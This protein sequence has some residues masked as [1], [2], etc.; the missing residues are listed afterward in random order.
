[1]DKSNSSAKI[2]VVGAG[3][4]GVRTAQVLAKHTRK[5]PGVEITLIDKNPFHTLMTELHEV[6]GA[7]CEPSSVRIPLET[8]FGGS[9]V[10]V[11]VDRVTSID[12]KTKKVITTTKEMDYDY[13]VLG[14]GAEPEFFGI[15]GVQEFSHTLWS[16]DDAVKIRE[17]IEGLFL[18]ASREADP[19]KR[20][21][22]LTLTVAGAGF[23]GVEMLGE[24]LE[25]R[26]PL[27]REY[28]IDEKEVRI[29][30]VEAMA[31][32]LPI[33]HKD[34]RKP[35]TDFITKS[36]GEILL[37]TAI[38]EV[39]AQ[40]FTTKDGRRVD[41]GILIWTCGVKGCKFAGELNI[42][43]AKDPC[44]N[45]EGVCVEE[46][47]RFNIKKK[48][49]L[50]TNIFLQSADSE[51]VY[52]V[53]DVLW[54]SE[55]GRALPQIVETAI[56]TG[57]TAAKN[58]LRDMENKPKLVHKPEYHGFMVSIGSRY[59]VADL[60]GVRLRGFMAMAM[61]HLINLHYLWEVAGVNSCWHYI[62]H[63]FLNIKDKRDQIHGHA[64]AKI[65]AYWALPLR[66]FT[67]AMWA[68]QG[69]DKVI[70]GWLAPYMGSKTGWMFSKG[71]V[72]AGLPVTP[73]AAGGAAVESA[74]AVAAATE[75][76]YEIIESVSEVIAESAYEGADALAASS[77]EIGEVVEAVQQGVADAVAA[78][79]FK[80][81]NLSKD[82]DIEKFL[83]NPI[84]PKD[85][86]LVQWNQFFMDNVVS[87][88]PFWLLQA[89][90]T[91]GE[92]AIGLALMAGLFTWPAAAASI[93]LCLVFTMS[94]MF[95]WTQLWYLFAALVF[96]GGSG[97]SVGLDNYVLPPLHRWWNGTALARKTKFFLGEPRYRHK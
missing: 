96:M 4:S 21:K 15:K 66:V 17:K 70:K 72:Q 67:G 33:L 16:Y 97:R 85:F 69:F 79:S 1:M 10:Q 95:A 24:L 34:L 13:L 58:I 40:G 6:A 94:G 83:S 2:I 39:D 29:L 22:L 76:G 30:L 84:L 74:D 77:E 64:A 20:K 19:E 37:N 46:D 80:F 56:Q 36:G 63:H 38:S 26:K 88:V 8:I 27:C 73:E 55:K 54:L 91:L 41:N 68:L 90:I 7:R 78:A 43:H 65:P 57:E 31:D 60:M 14:L 82:V 25:W 9:K 5:N 23:T 3:Y 51:K 45:Q 62:S 93:A 49:R 87:Q 50:I 18:Q 52:V 32:I 42:S 44:E 47:L 61:K 48:S 35:A 89:G 28:G 81:T 12:F 92:I 75:E 11:L 53:G 71:V 59:A 86:F